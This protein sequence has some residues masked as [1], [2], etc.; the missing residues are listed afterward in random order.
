VPVGAAG[1]ITSIDALRMRR[2]TT[3]HNAPEAPPLAAELEGNTITTYV[4]GEYLYE[5]MLRAIE[6]ATEHIYLASYIW[7]GDEVGQRFKDAVVAAAQR[8]VQVFIVFDGF[9]N[10]VVPAAFKTFPREVNVLQFPTVRGGWRLDARR[11]GR[12]H[13]KVLVVDDEVG[14]V[15]GYNIGSQY[16]TQWRDTHVRVEGDTVWELSNTFVDFWNRHCGKR[17]PQLPDGGAP[18]WNYP[19]RAAR[20]EPSRMVFPVRNVYLEAIDRASHHLYITQAYFIPDREILQGLLT[21]AARGVDVR[22]ITPQRSN[23]IV[24]DIVA[25]SYVTDLLAG[26]VRLFL[27]Q[28]AMVHAKTATADGQWSTVGTA[29]IDRLSMRGNYEVNLEV[30]DEGQAAVMEEVFAQDLRNCREMTAREWADRTLRHRLAERV[31]RPLQPL[32]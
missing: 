30:V 18:R 13:R 23:H 9:A 7:K 1:A 32:L 16:A 10:L 29:N 15:G 4:Y 12:D 27:Y 26:G 19:V 21:A 22:V 25:R 28:D 8:G 5:A 6:G 24:A 14:F 2:T 3:V 17:Q 20:N 11:T 31:L